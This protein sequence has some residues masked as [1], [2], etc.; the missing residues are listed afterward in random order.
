[1]GKNGEAIEEGSYSNR[2][3]PVCRTLEQAKEEFEE[4]ERRAESKYN[5][6]LALAKK[7]LDKDIEGSTLVINYVSLILRSDFEDDADGVTTAF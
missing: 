7:K 6:A 3:C 4:A 2:P 5:E 1:M